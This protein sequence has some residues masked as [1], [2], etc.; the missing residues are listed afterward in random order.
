[1][2]EDNKYY[3]WTVWCSV[4]KNLP[5]SERLRKLNFPIRM[6]MWMS[7]WCNCKFNIVTEPDKIN[8][9]SWL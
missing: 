2:N 6:F 1:M 8:Q 4:L 7:D 3:L 5:Y 9:R